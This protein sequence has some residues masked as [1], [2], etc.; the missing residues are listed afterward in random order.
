MG[1]KELIDELSAELDA[2]RDISAK[3]EEEKRDLTASERTAVKEHFERG[4]ILKDRI[5][6]AKADE[7]LAGDIRQL[8]ADIGLNFGDPGTM[9]GGPGLTVPNTASR[10]Y[11]P[12]MTTSWGKAVADA[13]STDPGA[14]MPPLGPNDPLPVALPA[15][16]LVELGRPVEWSRDLIP[17]AEAA[18]GRFRYLRQT[19]RGWAAA[20]TAAGTAKPVTDP[21]LSWQEGRVGIVPTLSEPLNRYD[22]IDAPIL[23]DFVNGNLVDSVEYGIENSIVNGALDNAIPGSFWG[24]LRAPGVLDHPFDAAVTMLDP[25]RLGMNVLSRPPNWHPTTGIVLAD[26]DWTTLELAKDDNGR[27]LLDGPAHDRASRRLWSTPVVVSPV[28]DPGTALLGDFAGSSALFV[29]DGGN[30]HLSYS[31]HTQDNFSRNLITFR[32]E[33]RVSL[34]VMLPGAF[35]KVALAASPRAKAA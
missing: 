26:D 29:A 12:A 16:R 8:G 17:H 27:Y 33:A 2:A 19:R 23:T 18:G 25:I 34:A 1:V 14:K 22:F 35:V 10:R 4:K 32:A 5:T 21:G 20:L 13:A 9:T 30:V 7:Q 3:A 6:E 15:P 28:L 11:A 24:F 31:E